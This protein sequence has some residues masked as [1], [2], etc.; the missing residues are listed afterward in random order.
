MPQA[1]ELATLPLLPD[2]DIA[3]PGSEGHSVISGMVGTLVNQKG[4]LGIHYGRQHENPDNL[5]LAIDWASI[6]S[7]KD[8]EQTEAYLPFVQ[9]I[10]TIMSGPVHMQHVEFREPLAAAAVAPI[11]EML[12]LYFPDHVDRANVE[13]TLV[14]FL[15]TIV[16][17][18]KGFVGYTTGW[19]VEEL[20]HEK[21][22]GKARAYAVTIGWE[23]LEAHMAYRDTHTFKEDIVKV[24]AIAKGLA[25]MWMVI[26]GG[27][28]K[29]AIKKHKELAY[30]AFTVYEQRLR[31]L[32]KHMDD[33]K[34]KDFWGLVYDRRNTLQYYTFWSVI[35]VGFLS[36]LLGLMSLAVGIAQAVFAYRA[37]NLPVAATTTNST[38]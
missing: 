7:H 25:L 14:D 4:Y 11:V 30:D 10:G 17:N 34:P 28:T 32:R 15:Q 20:E 9:K 13:T 37:L 21:I 38:T 19:V 2:V 22:E 12:T 24:R 26:Y 36:I 1:T 16:D 18:A 23:S 33:C 35:A 5:V 6:K 27:G 8:F 3:T 29:K 31:Y